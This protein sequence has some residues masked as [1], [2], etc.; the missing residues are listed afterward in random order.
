MNSRSDRPLIVTQFG[1]FLF[2]NFPLRTSLIL[3]AG[4]AS[5][6]LEGLG[7]ALLA[8][9]F[10]L[11]GVAS[12]SQA[13]TPSRIGKLLQQVTRF[14]GVELTLGVVL[15]A[16]LSIFLLQSVI[17]ILNERLINSTRFQ[18]ASMLRTMLFDAV[19]A[20]RWEFIAKQ[21]TGVMTNA[22]TQDPIRAAAAFLFLAALVRA[23]IAILIYVGLA[24]A[25]S[26]QMTLIAVAIAGIGVWLLRSRVAKGQ[27]YGEGTIQANA[28]VQETVA[29]MLAC[30]K[31]VKGF[32]AIGAASDRF[33]RAVRELT[34]IQVKDSRNRTMVGAL[35]QPLTAIFLL[36]GLYLALSVFKM[37]V[38]D[39][40]VLLVVLFRLT[41]RVSD[42]QM[43][44]HE[45]N[46][47]LPSLANIDR[48]SQ[49]AK[50]FREREGG[51]PFLGLQ[52]AIQM[53]AVWFAYENKEPVLRGV[54]LEIR[55]GEMVAI[56]GASGGGKTTII[57][58]LMGFLRPTQGEV[59]IDGV[60][61][62]G[63]SLNDW[64]GRIGYVPQDVHLLNDTVRA[65]LLWGRPTATGVEI[66]AVAK[67]VHAHE[68]IQDLPQGYDAVI[69]SRGV[70][71][72]GGQRQRLALARA[73]VRKPEF[74]ILDEAM[75][76]LDAESEFLIQQT[77]DALVRHMS[78]V[79]V[80]HRLATIQ[81]ADRIYVLEHGRIVE[82]GS[83]QA[84]TM[85][86]GRF[87]ELRR[88]QALV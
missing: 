73:L 32:G 34:D 19:L 74:L 70:L 23:C 30:A 35:Y 1:R 75:S 83:W 55:K 67:L 64:H 18:F 33:R 48:V 62:D 31:L 13:G 79:V 58:L 42:L 57:D 87:N 9:M 5:N 38:P 86:Q 14:F 59:L 2:R 77:L 54:N 84:L 36:S 29:E 26:W 49:L 53:Q 37:A 41:P 6:L 66:E 10:T 51:Q 81:R 46:S 65:N 4:A 50:G 24:L 56:V 71:L 16:L 72:S 27:E 63:L 11:A 60:S 40:M 52:Q 44:L 78:I 69:G 21:K 43:G 8:P 25:F 15:V 12:V 80:A 3:S 76:A 39:V 85:A 22:L 7:L 61:L 47:L 17:T 20:A 82:S 68:F 28:W 45:L 88:L